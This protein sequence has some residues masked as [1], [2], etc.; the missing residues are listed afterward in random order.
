MRPI[1]KMG[2]HT[3]SIATLGACSGF[4]P[5]QYITGFYVYGTDS[6]GTRTA[7][8]VEY[9]EQ[10]AATG[11]AAFPDGGKARVL[12]Q[13]LLL[14]FC[15]APAQPLRFLGYLPQ[16]DPSGDVDVRVLAWHPDAFDIAFRYQAPR[17]SFEEYR[18]AIAGGTVPLG[19]SVDT[20]Q[21]SQ[22]ISPVCQH[23]V[24]S[25]NASSRERGAKGFYE[26][27]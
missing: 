16:S 21:A 9:G 14:Y 20:T 7:V 10:Q 12:K 4:G 23:V 1:L 8:A 5:T 22:A 11:I 27:P 2:M 3:V 19:S 6:S 18:V 25:L 13:G 15:N 17:P 24:D 26:R